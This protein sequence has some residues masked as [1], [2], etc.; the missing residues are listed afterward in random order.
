MYIVLLVLFFSLFRFSL[1]CIYEPE[2][3]G[4]QYDDFYSY[5]L[6]NLVLG[7]KSVPLLVKPSLF[8]TL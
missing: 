5:N 7:G 2:V 4:G 1:S 6:I 3:L 8:I